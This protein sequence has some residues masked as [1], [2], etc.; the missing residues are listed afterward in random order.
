VLGGVT[1]CGGRFLVKTGRAIGGAHP[2]ALI[3][4][5][6]RIAQHG[7][8]MSS[9]AHELPRPIDAQFVARLRRLALKHGVRPAAEALGLSRHVFL[10][11]V[12]GL[13]LDNCQRDAVEAGLRHVY[14]D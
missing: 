5:L 14:E 1:R 2:V 9:R 13:P 12:A 4:N 3:D 11:A 6:P 8:P 10:V 7:D